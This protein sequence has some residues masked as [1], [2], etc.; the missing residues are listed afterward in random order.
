MQ[1]PLP[2]LNIEDGKPSLSFEMCEVFE[3]P[4]DDYQE[5]LDILDRIEREKDK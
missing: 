3:I 4:Q 2:T 1:V 5:T